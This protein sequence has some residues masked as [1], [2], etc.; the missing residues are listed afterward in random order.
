MDLT[1]LVLLHIEP[2][3]QHTRLLS[4]QA[5]VDGIR[6]IHALV[7]MNLHHASTAPEAIVQA[8]EVDG[9]DAVLAQRGGAHDTR[10]DGDIEVRF[11]EHGLG[12]LGHDFGEGD[13]F[14][15]SRAL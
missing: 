11:L 2:A 5:P 10:L 1:F 8:P 14:G 12:V 9:A 7:G 13:E 4:E 15:V 6:R 3:Q